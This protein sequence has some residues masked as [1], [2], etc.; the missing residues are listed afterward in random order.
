M[1][2]WSMAAALLVLLAG[3]TL[4]S[5]AEPKPDDKTKQA[6]STA[7][8]TEPATTINFIKDLDLHFESLATLGSRIE[9]ARRNADPVALATCANYLA[10]AETASGKKA[11]LTAEALTKEA[12]ELA[13]LRDESAELK[14]VAALVKDA[15][16]EL[17]PLAEKA[18]K[19]EAD[20][21]AA[22]KS[23]ERPRGIWGQVT[24][25][26]NTSYKI[27]VWEDGHELGWVNPYDTFTFSH[28]IRHGTGHNSV[29]NCRSEDGSYHYRFVIDYD[30]PNFTWT[31]N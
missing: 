24:A 29:L 4:S 18:A 26:N 16:A 11:S 13:K 1:L 25:V 21:R 31:L 23:G 28:R 22:F 17:T 19:R 3:L 12:V 15:S 9:E 10:A 30:V 14:A 7:E 5:G 20:E 8:K 6:T 2:R 27:F